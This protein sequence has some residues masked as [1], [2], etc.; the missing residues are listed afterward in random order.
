MIGLAK[1]SILNFNDTLEKT[2]AAC[3]Q[4]SGYQTGH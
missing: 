2:V 4:Q 1:M 3:L